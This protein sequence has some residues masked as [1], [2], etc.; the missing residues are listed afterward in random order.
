MGKHLV[1][2]NEKTMFFVFENAIQNKDTKK[3]PKRCQKDNDYL[4]FWK[5]KPTVFLELHR[6]CIEGHK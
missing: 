1:L 3:T 6:N 2:C 5:R 4:L